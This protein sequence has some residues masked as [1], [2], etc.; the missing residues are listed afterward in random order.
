MALGPQDNSST[1]SDNVS[2]PQMLNQIVSRLRAARAV[3][4]V[5]HVRPDGDCIGSMLAVHHLLEEWAVPHAMAAEQMPINGYAA[6]EGFERILMKPDPQ[7]A[8]DLIV[9]VDCATQ[10][11][12]LTGWT[13]PAP[14]IN[15]DHHASNTRY[16]QI[17][18]ID[19]AAAA[20]GE[21]LYNVV[22]HAGARLN[23]A[24]AE[25]LLIALT[26]DTGSFRFSNTGPRQHRIAARLL[27]AGASVERVTRIAFSSH[28]PASMRLTGHVLSTMHLECD[29]RLAWSEIRKEVYAQHGGEGVAPENLADSLRAIHGVKVSL[30]FHEIGEDGLRLNLRSDGDVD[31]SRLAGLCGGGGHPCAAGAFISTTHYD[32]ERD[33]LLQ[34]VKETICAAPN[35]KG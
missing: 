30:L 26:T 15:I 1:V 17:N 35:S 4:I 2:T 11:R 31:V 5:G 34:L 29:G 8:P 25:A 16:G 27:E 10:D 13:P 28:P 21:M 14:V 7:L 23:P 20:T 3:Q 19:P 6:L 9:Y 24:M 33:R 12:G 32:Q 18:W 22:V